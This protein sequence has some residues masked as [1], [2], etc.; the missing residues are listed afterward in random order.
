M[1]HMVC[2]AIHDV[3]GL[4]SNAIFVRTTSRLA[5]IGMLTC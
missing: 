5:H 4:V 1:I 2:I 3:R